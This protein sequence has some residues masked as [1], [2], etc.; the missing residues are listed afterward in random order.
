MTFDNIYFQIAFG[1]VSQTMTL[2]IKR[3]KKKVH[4]SYDIE[5]SMRSYYKHNNNTQMHHIIW[6]SLTFLI[7]FLK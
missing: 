7:T 6:F 2:D 4:I 1:Y 3:Y 5:S